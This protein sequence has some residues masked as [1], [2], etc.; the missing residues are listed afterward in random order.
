MLGAVGIGMLF[1]LLPWGLLADR[2]SERVV[3]AIGLSV[4]GVA[5]VAAGRTHSYGALVAALVRRRRDSARA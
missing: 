5:L 1:T 4:A 2:L 3:I